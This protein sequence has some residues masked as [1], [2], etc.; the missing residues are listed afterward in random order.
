MA[1]KVDRLLQRLYAVQHDLESLIPEQYRVPENQLFVLKHERPPCDM[2]C[3]LWRDAEAKVYGATDGVE[4]LW[5]YLDYRLQQTAKEQM[6]FAE[7][8]SG[9]D[10]DD[11]T[12]DSEAEP[13]AEVEAQAATDAETGQQEP[14]GAGTEG[15]VNAAPYAEKPSEASGGKTTET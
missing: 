10:A 9:L 2:L 11:E 6:A 7:A 15:N 3:Q 5:C 4:D 13:A 12:E 8:E 14:A 1:R